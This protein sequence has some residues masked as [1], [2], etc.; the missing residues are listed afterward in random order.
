M[1]RGFTLLECTLAGA[2]LCLLSVALLK[3]VSVATRVARENAELL[4]AD[5][6]VWDA[7]WTTFNGDYDSLEAMAAVTATAS[8]GLELSE[9]AAPDLYNE[10]CKPLL[11][12]WVSSVPGFPSLKSVTA[13]LEWGVPTDARAGSDK[14]RYALTN[15]VYRSDVR[16]TQAP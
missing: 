7:L 6:I 9:A 8:G 3:G 14:R 2:L 1:R 13:A 15:F 16:R 4:A 12:V 11:K 10:D 5:G